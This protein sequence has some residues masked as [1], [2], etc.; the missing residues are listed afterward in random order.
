MYYFVRIVT[1]QQAAGPIFTR[2]ILAVGPSIPTRLCPFI[3]LS[4]PRLGGE[5]FDRVLAQSL[6]IQ[7]SFS[8]PVF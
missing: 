1:I 3:L 7:V 6:N 2:D 5:C 4:R 8:D